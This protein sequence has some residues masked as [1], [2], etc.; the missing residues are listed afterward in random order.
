VASF[1]KLSKDILT[2]AELGV[3]DVV[4]HASLDNDLGEGEEE[5]RRLVLWM[6]ETSTWPTGAIEVHSANP[7]AKKYMEGMIERYAPFTKG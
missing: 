4:T 5:G 3:G 2:A 7:V 6:A 1:F